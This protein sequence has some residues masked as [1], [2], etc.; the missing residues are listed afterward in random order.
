MTNR[1][2]AF[3]PWQMKR[4]HYADGLSTPGERPRSSGRGKRLSEPA[5]PAAPVQRIFMRRLLRLTLD[6]F[7]DVVI[8]ADK[9]ESCGHKFVSECTPFQSDVLEGVIDRTAFVPSGR[10]DFHAI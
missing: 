8:I 5:L 3:R 2:F 7:N 1:H 4:P 6:H 10:H 9:A